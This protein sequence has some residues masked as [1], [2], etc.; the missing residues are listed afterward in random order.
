MVYG[1][2]CPLKQPVPFVHGPDLEVVEN[3]AT[4]LLATNVCVPLLVHVTVTGT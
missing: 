4:Q 1:N 3:Q 2:G